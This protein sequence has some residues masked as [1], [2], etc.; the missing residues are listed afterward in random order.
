M[1]VPA[2]QYDTGNYNGGTNGNSNGSDGNGNSNGSLNV[3]NENGNQNGNQNDSAGGLLPRASFVSCRTREGLQ[4]QSALNRP[5]LSFNITVAASLP[6]QM[7]NGSHGQLHISTYK[8]GSVL[9]AMHQGSREYVPK[10]GLNRWCPCADLDQAASTA[11]ASTFQAVAGSKKSATAKA[12]ADRK[13]KTGTV[14]GSVK[15]TSGGGEP[16]TTPLPSG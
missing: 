14:Q 4:S 7:H 2:G 13:S 12:A 5:T 11:A 1:A 8:L 6:T 9:T 10:E 16:D 15:T 3:G